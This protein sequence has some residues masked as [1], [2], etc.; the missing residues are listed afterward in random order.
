MVTMIYLVRHAHPVYSSDEVTRPLSEQ[1]EKDARQVSDALKKEKID[2]VVS[3][4][5]QRAI[6]TIEGVAQHFGKDSFQKNHWR[7]LKMLSE[8]FGLTRISLGWR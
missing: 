5:Y 6:Q 3:S 7:T 1:G 4:P 8:R 2:I